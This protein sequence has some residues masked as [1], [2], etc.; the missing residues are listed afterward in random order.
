ML[1][2]LLVLPFLLP[3]LLCPE[4]KAHN[5]QTSSADHVVDPSAELIE[6]VLMLFEVVFMRVTF[7]SGHMKTGSGLALQKRSSAST[8]IVGQYCSHIKLAMNMFACERYTAY[9]NYL[10]WEQIKA[11]AIAI[12]VP[13]SPLRV[14]PVQHHY[15]TEPFQIAS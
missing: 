1:H 3:D 6:V 4:V 7:D 11:D 5:A 10:F 15:G 8:H 14:G 13:S 9:Q 2:L 12:G